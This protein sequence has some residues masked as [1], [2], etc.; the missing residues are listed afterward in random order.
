M[1]MSTIR[2]S[3]GTN[4]F[5]R[6]WGTGKPIVFLAGWTLSSD[7]WAYQMSPLSR[8]GFRCVA[9]DRRAHGRSDDPGRGFDYDTLSDDIASVLEALDLRDVCLVAPSFASGE[10]VRYLTRHKRRRVARV[11]LLAPAAIPF[12]LQTKDNP[13]SLAQPSNSGAPLS[14]YRPRYASAIEVSSLRSR[15]SLT[16]LLTTNERPWRLTSG[17]ASSCFSSCS[18]KVMWM[19]FIWRTS[20]FLRSGF[21]GG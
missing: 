18:S 5:I 19:R 20:R 16:A 1:R 11:L 8:Q 12:L 21:G 4:L 6:D 7:A 10:A 2:T 9:I 17:S 13:P 15:Y 14:P 3:D